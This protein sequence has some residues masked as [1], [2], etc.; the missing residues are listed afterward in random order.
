MELARRPVQN[1]KYPSLA[2]KPGRSN[3]HPTH[4]LASQ[5]IQ[6]HFI[7]RIPHE[8]NRLCA[9]SIQLV[10]EIRSLL[11]NRS[12]LFLSIV[13]CFFLT[14]SPPPQ[15]HTLLKI[16]FFSY[17]FN[18][19]TDCSRKNRALSAAAAI[20]TMSSISV[21]LSQGRKKKSYIRSLGWRI[22]RPP[23]RSGLVDP[24]PPS[25]R[26]KKEPPERPR[27]ESW[28]YIDLA[29]GAFLLMVFCP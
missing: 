21:R 13:S 5:Q 26:P 28:F 18:S 12:N 19:G 9:S 1:K 22:T 16:F 17:S 14:P 4:P 8:I 11:Y 7:L 25:L 27:L 6:V 29:S 3:T 20:S 2:A 15:P 10:F 23:A 24:C